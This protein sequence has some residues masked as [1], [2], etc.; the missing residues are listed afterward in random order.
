[1]WASAIPLDYVYRNVLRRRWTSLFTALGMALVVFVFAAMLMLVQG[2]ESTLVQ[3]GQSDNLMLIRRSAE[4]EV[5]SSIARGQ[6][7]IVEGLDGIQTD[8]TGEPW[9]TKEIA[10]LINL[11]KRGTLK[12]SNITVRGTSAKGLTLRP[13]V[14]LIAGR[15]FRSGTSEI[16]AGKS[17]AERFQ[18]V[19]LGETLHFAQRDW[20]VVGV[21]D[22]GRTAFNSEV[23]GNA[24]QMMQAFRRQEFSSLLFKA[25][26]P[27]QL[28]ARLEM[29]FKNDPRLP[30]EAK[31]ETQFYGDQSKALALFIRIM[32]TVLS[33]IFSL[34][35]IIGA[36]ITMYA[37]VAT[38]T[39]EIGTLR[40]IGFS[41]KSVLWAFLAE[42]VCMSLM[43]GGGGVLFAACL[44][45]ISLST[46]NFQTFSELVFGFDLT[47]SIIVQSLAFAVVMGVMGGLLPAW[48][49]SRLSV[50]EALRG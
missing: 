27:D 49:A 3:T 38:R 30:L 40:A 34:G 11:P 42:S 41:R 12:P 44:Q 14:R 18:G 29:Q 21:F 10:V 4:T 9:L 20:V 16:I 17:I 32:G 19:G 6:A 36:M 35:A 26:N 47:L 50:V 24:E 7:A 31:P 46:T 37:T 25:R 23:W 13:Q 28:L 22:A 45:P 8:A 33:V 15:L 43:G 5:Q 1:M 39:P 2:L 48:R